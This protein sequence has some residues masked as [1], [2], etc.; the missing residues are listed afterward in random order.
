MPYVSACG[1]DIGAMNCAATKDK[2]AEGIPPLQDES[3]SYGAAG[4]H[5][6]GGGGWGA[7]AVGGATPLQD[8]SCRYSGSPDDT[9]HCTSR[10]G[11]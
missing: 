10:N 5:G 11:R 8:E 4:G 9:R 6:A 7:T 2:V 1:L 3:G